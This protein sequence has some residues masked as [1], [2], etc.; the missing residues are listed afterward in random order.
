MDAT[1]SVACD[2]PTR[3]QSLPQEIAEDSALRSAPGIASPSA[4]TPATRPPQPPPPL[5]SE[6]GARPSDVVS[7][8]GHHLG[9]RHRQ[10]ACSFTGCAPTSGGRGIHDGGA[11]PTDR[12]QGTGGGDPAELSAPSLRTTAGRTMIHSPT[13]ISSTGH[14]MRVVRLHNVQCLHLEEEAEHQEKDQPD[15][16]FDHRSHL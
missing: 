1:D 2:S 8:N 4:T 6:S 11:A 3:N 5:S 15:L 13:R 7:G 12:A 16:H 9:C 10:V 14:T